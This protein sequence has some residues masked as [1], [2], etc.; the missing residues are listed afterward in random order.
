[1]V[2]SNRRGF[3]GKSGE[4]I[5]RMKASLTKGKS[6]DDGGGGLGISHHPVDVKGVT[7]RSRKE[8]G[9]PLE[10]YPSKAAMKLKS[11]QIC[12]SCML[13]LTKRGNRGLSEKREMARGKKRT[14][15]ENAWERSSRSKS[16]TGVWRDST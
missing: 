4:T 6:V 2:L 12:V 5:G 15:G 10:R 14:K 13:G 8:V 7:S 3:A 9:N 11:G 16:D 1:M